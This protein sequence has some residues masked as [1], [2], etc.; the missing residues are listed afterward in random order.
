LRSIRQYKFFE[1]IVDAGTC[2]RFELKL[3][4]VLFVLRPPGRGQGSEV[5]ELPIIL[6]VEDDQ[7]IQ[8]LVEE[9]FSGSGFE[10]MRHRWERDAGLRLD[11]FLLSPD[12]KKELVGVDRAVRGKVS[13]S[14]HAPAWIVLDR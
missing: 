6:V 7:M 5:L 12:L 10:S 13:A 8:S 2:V 9:T 4:C 1:A 14:D 11:H 3:P